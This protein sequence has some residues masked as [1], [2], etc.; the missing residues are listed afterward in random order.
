MM[1]SMRTSVKR[2]NT[3]D[4]LGKFLGVI[5]G[6]CLVYGCGKKTEEPAEPTDTPAPSPVSRSE[7]YSQFNGVKVRMTEDTVIYDEQHRKI[8]TLYSGTCVDIDSDAGN[9]LLKLRDEPYYISGSAAEDSQRWYDV[10]TCLLPLDDIIR[11][12]SDYTLY[13]ERGNAF[14]QMQVS[15]DYRAYVLPGEERWGVLFQGGT[16]FIDP[17]DITETWKEPLERWSAE[18]LPVLMYHF[19]Y[20][21]ADGGSRIDGNY[22]EQ[23]ELREQ[24]QY[25]RDND[26]AT[27]NMHE[28]LYYMQGR[29]LIPGNSVAITIDD[30]DP[31]VHQYAFPVFQEYGM[32]AT[33]FIIGGWEDPSMSWDFWEMREAGLELQS[34]SFLMHQGG[35]PG[36]GHGG[37]LMCVDYN[38]GVSDT[39]MSFDYVDGGFVYCY[40]FGDYNDHAKQI[41]RDGGAKLAFTTE[42]GVIRPGMDLLQL[43]RIRVTGGAGLDR[44]AGSLKG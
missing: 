29:A 30:G 43:P 2:S 39:V 33:L 22:V 17:Q 24:L 12:D 40:P 3:T 18:H 26:Y 34:H 8:G 6:I 35:C 44:F 11:T 4:T 31:S 27:L 14:A 23:N 10:R 41:I 1:S 37:R 28:V 20:S 7:D 21:E 5:L 16:A 32:R 42:N 38:E 19:F 15:H 25:L 9:G 13:D 36:M